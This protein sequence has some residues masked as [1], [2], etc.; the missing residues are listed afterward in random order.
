VP[1]LPSDASS[2]RAGFAAP[3]ASVGVLADGTPYF[4][5]IGQ[6]VS[7]GSS[8][9]CH[10]CGRAFRS[11]AAHLASHGWTKVQ[12][13]EAFGLELS[14]PLEGTQ[15]RKLR[16]AAFSARLVFEPALRAGSAAGR[17]RARTGEL[18][19]DAATAARGRPFPQ[20]RI[21]RS[22]QAVSGQGQARIARANRDRADLRLAR[23]AHEAALRQGYPGIGQLILDKVRAGRSL[24]AISL[25]C[26]LH[27]DWMARHLNRVDPAAAELARSTR[28]LTLD[29]RW[30]P[31]IR[32][33]GFDDVAGYL[34]QRHLVEHLSINAIAREVAVSAP[35]VKSAL[36]RHGLTASPHAAKRHAAERREQEVAAALG[37][38]SIADFVRR[39]RMLG[40]TWR[41]IAAESGQ[42]ET[43]LRRHGASV[44]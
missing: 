17:Q 29:A 3:P 1:A 40:Q 39:R 28:Y 11:V 23:I 10:L 2:A 27:K 25:D 9:L 4:G 15:T 12:Y 14:Q 18:T 5:P 24:A 35:A 44:G 42:P 16:A 43:W 21:Q 22:R 30:L 13:C 33:L 20:Q 8:V 26:G 32:G 31:A 41:E 7:D 37:V 6:V 19:R 36:E 34:R 38:E